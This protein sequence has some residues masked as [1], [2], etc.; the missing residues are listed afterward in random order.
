MMKYLDSNVAFILMALINNLQ[1]QH[2]LLCIAAA[3]VPKGIATHSDENEQ[4]SFAVQH[5]T[6]SFIARPA[7][8]KQRHTSITKRWKENTML[9]FCC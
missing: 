4:K 3:I 5:E 9:L 1:R 7:T 8:Q 6:I 2:N